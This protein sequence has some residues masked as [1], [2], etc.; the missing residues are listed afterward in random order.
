MA[1]RTN[2]RLSAPVHEAE[3]GRSCCTGRQV[4]GEL[5]DDVRCSRDRELQS[6]AAFGAVVTPVWYAPRSPAHGG[7]LASGPRQ[8][9]QVEP[10]GPA[11]QE[12]L[13]A[14][15]EAGTGVQRDEPASPLHPGFPGNRNSGPLGWGC[16]GAGFQG[17]QESPT[18][19]DGRSSLNHLERGGD[20]GPLRV[21]AGLRAAGAERGW[22]GR[23]RGGFGGAAPAAAA[24]PHP[25]PLQVLPN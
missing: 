12:T 10:R 3:V 17:R 21:G 2:R 23:G 6:D 8:A 5:G 11:R 19:S 13:P 20:G 25:G 7:G 14:R 18:Q 22:W 9:G 15:R 1:Q 24:L 16:R 4:G